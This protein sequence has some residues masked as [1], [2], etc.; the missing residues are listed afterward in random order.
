MV[1]RSVSEIS[2]IPSSSGAALRDIFLLAFLSP[3][4]VS[5]AAQNNKETVALELG[6]PIERVLARGQSHSYRVALTAGQFLHVI[7]EGQAIDVA[8]TLYDPYGKEIVKANGPS[9][10]REPASVAAIAEATG[11]YELKV[12]AADDEAGRGRYKGRLE[13]VRAATGEDKKRVIELAELAE[14][15]VLARQSDG[16]RDKGQYDEAI[17]FIKRALAVRER[18]LGPEHPDVAIALNSLAELYGNKP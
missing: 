10:A 6:R 15:T 18:L 14:A 17:P 1:V 5:L 12:R 4:M 11:V 7:V 3:P 2:P 16:L 8:V 9:G 13:E